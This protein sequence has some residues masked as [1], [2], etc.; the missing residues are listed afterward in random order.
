MNQKFTRMLFVFVLSLVGTMSYGAVLSSADSCRASFVYNA[1]DGTVSFIDSSASASP[2]VAYT[3]NFGDGTS[4]NLK[5]PTHVY[6]SGTYQANVC[7]TVK[8]QLNITGTVCKLITVRSAKSCSAEFVFDYSKDSIGSG[9]TF[10]FIDMSSPNVIGRTWSFGDGTFSSLQN[11][12]HTYNI[13]P[14]ATMEASLKIYTSTGCYDTVYRTISVPNIT[15]AGNCDANFSYRYIQDSINTKATFEFTDA[16]SGMG[17]NILETYWDFGDGSTSVEKYPRHTYTLPEG[18]KVNVRELITTSLN[19]R[20]TMV[21]TIT[22]PYLSTS[23]S[24]YASFYYAAIS[25]SV[26]STVTVYFTDKSSP[27]VLSRRW[28]FGDGAYS[29]LKDPTHTYNLLPGSH[30]TV[31]EYVNTSSMC[32]D[33]VSKVVVIPY[34]VHTDTC[35]ANFS[36]A[37]D[38]TVSSGYGYRFTNT[39]SANA[40]S[41]YWDFGDSTSS[42]L[43]DPRHVYRLSSSSVIVSLRIATSNNC[44]NTVKKTIVLPNSVKKYLISGKVKGTDGLLSSGIVVLYQKNSNGRFILKDAKVVTD[45]LF[46]F[47]QL[48]P[49]KYIMYAIPDITNSSKYLPTYYV[50][51]IHWS[52]ADVIDLKSNA[53]GLTL[54]MIAIKV[55]SGGAGSIS[56][57]V[58][59]A[60]YVAS[61]S[62]STLKSA[63]QITYNVCLYTESGEIISSVAPDLNGNFT[64]DGLPYGKYSL[65]VEYPNLESSNMT[66]NLSP[67]SPT[68]SGVQFTVDQI[69]MAVK[70]VEDGNGVTIYRTSASQIAV[71]VSEAGKYNISIVNITGSVLANASVLVFEANEEK[72]IDIGSVPSGMY[73]IK[74]QNGKDVHVKKIVK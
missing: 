9:Y 63:S 68:A 21:R 32:F 35:Y 39:S 51:K 71:R 61:Q 2:I 56:G 1:Q 16:S 38:S 11:P 29:T 72:I 28:N 57:K 15:P 53:Q 42:V 64:F 22:I 66:V 55:L 47:E 27:N 12:S 44:T 41:W 25:D 13:V 34:P 48:D 31:W 59:S 4:S 14:G 33:S 67:T 10:H 24:C 20:D 43:K 60:G 30:I 70:A 3:W 40:T 69:A 8:N 52:N 18:T 6:A 74:V 19:C 23:D 45:G 73:L 7:L 37:M 58:L 62:E 17:N 50:N 26:S 49:A 5:N 65:N 54:Q 46:K 36:Y